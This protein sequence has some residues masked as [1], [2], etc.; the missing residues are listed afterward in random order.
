MFTS[1]IG[2]AAFPFNAVGAH[3]SAE[4]PP[5]V[6]LAVAV[7]VSADG[8]AWLPW[9]DIVEVEQGRDG[10]FYCENLIMTEGG[11]YLQYRLIMQAVT[12]SLAP[13]LSEITLTYIDSTAG[14]DLAEA[15]GSVLGHRLGSA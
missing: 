6:Q 11:R 5:D 9:Q 1:T 10:R 15:G 8:V 14:P 12:P 13:K 3:W 4:V 2:I 7:R